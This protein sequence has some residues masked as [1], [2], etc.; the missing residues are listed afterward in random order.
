[1]SADGRWLWDGARWIPRDGALASQ[2]L[3]VHPNPPVAQPQNAMQ[4]AAPVVMYRPPTN[5]LAVTSLVSGIVSWFLCPLVG[6][7]V[8]VITGHMAHGQIKTSGESGAGM[9]TAGL[10]L[11]YIHLA[12]WAVFLLFWLVVLG[13][14]AVVGGIVGAA[15]H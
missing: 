11:G 12:A 8:A 2:P 9:A 3:A 5:S 14:L 10:V 1:V 6:A 4:Y 7:V 15:N 13:G